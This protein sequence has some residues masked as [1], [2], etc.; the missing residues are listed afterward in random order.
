MNRYFLALTFLILSSCTSNQLVKP[1]LDL[2]ESDLVFD[3]SIVALQT[4][5]APTSNL[6]KVHVINVRQGNCFLVQYPNGNNMLVDCGS[7]SSRT[8]VPPATIGA[9]IDALVGTGTIGTVVLTHPDK[10]HISIV[11]YIS[12]AQNPDYVHI[13][14]AE[15]DYSRIA[16]WFTTVKGNGATIRTYANNYFNLK[17]INEF[18]SRGTRHN[19]VE[20]YVLAANVGGDKNTHSIVLQIEH[21]VTEVLLTG[22]ATKQTDAFI[23]KNWPAAVIKSTLVLFGHHG[24]NHSSS[25]T[26]INYAARN[27]GIFSASAS[28]RGYGHPRCSIYNLVLP[29]LDKNGV[30]DMSVASHNVT[31]WDDATKQYV[32]KQNVISGI[33]GTADQKNMTF[34]TDGGEYQVLVDQL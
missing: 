15:T 11:P 27:V 12:K 1:N 2:V 4:E 21:A 33:F 16:P 23:L 17:P 22:D 19:D 25:S 34:V 10:D 24:S 3:A 18:G 14:M 8:S 26:F 7:S 5:N 31:C 28:H 6:M 29:N 20:V 9:T 13:S 32:I 30:D